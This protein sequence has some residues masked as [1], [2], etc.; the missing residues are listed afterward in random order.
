VSQSR[1]EAF[2]E[3]IK[4]NPDE[5][6]VWYGLATEYSKLERWADAASALKQVIRCNPDYTAAYQM[7]G[8]VLVRLDEKDEARRIWTE[9]IAAATRTGA[10]KAGQ[11]MQGLLAESEAENQ[12]NFCS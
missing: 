3:M 10:W 2:E 9:G 6:M 5:V 11:H 4:D 1:I 8:S 12:S 7:L